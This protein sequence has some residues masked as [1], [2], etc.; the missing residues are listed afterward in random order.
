M[1]TKNFL[2]HLLLPY[3]QREIEAEF[4]PR[5]PYDKLPEGYIHRMSLLT[6]TFEALCKVVGF[7]KSSDGSE[8]DEA[9]F[10]ETYDTIYDLA[11]R[12][13]MRI[14]SRELDF[15]LNQFAWRFLRENLIPYMTINRPSDSIEE[16]LNKLWGLSLETYPEELAAKLSGEIAYLEN[17]TAYLQL[18]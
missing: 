8:A 7:E 14:I 4:S 15:T 17:P 5:I 18:Q 13:E 2:T 1:S 6:S 10:A 9:W 11:T 16:R 3:S 12:I